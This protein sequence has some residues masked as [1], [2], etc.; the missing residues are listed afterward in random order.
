MEQAPCRWECLAE[1]V[2]HPVVVGASGQR[3]GTRGFWRVMARSAGSIAAVSIGLFMIIA[4]IFQRK[5][6]DPFAGELLAF[7]VGLVVFGIALP[8]LRKAGLSTTGGGRGA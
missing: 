4:A 1:Q 3:T 6:R 8:R 2:M 7:G 5:G